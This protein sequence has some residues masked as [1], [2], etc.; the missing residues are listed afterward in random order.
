MWSDIIFIF[1]YFSKPFTMFRSCIITTLHLLILF[2]STAQEHHFV[3]PVIA[4]FGGIY[5]LEHAT[6]KPD[7]NLSYKIIIDLVSGQEDPMKINAALNNVARMINLHVVGG[8]SSDSLAVI[9][10]TH[11]GATTRF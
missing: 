2:N 3:N 11:G 10:A 9:L 1:K 7:P 4:E 6:V 8:V 5:D